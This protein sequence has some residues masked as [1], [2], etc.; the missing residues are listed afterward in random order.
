ML[1]QFKEYIMAKIAKFDYYTACAGQANDKDSVIIITC[2]DDNRQ[3]F[4]ISPNSARRFA[5]DI[6]R[7]ANEIDPIVDQNEQ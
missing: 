4:S 7:A 2:I 5:D 6:L 3:T 1:S